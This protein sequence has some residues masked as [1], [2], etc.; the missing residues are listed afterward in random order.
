[1]SVL[2]SFFEYFCVHMD[3]WLD[4]D[5]KPYRASSKHYCFIEIDAA[6]WLGVMELYFMQ[7]WPKSQNH[8]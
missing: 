6:S 4:T 5:K 3:T 7:S 2:H 8:Y 1:M